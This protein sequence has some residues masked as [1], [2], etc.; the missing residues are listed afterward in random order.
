MNT[1]QSNKTRTTSSDDLQTLIDEAYPTDAWQ[2]TKL[3]SAII[4]Q[5]RFPMRNAACQNLIDDLDLPALYKRYFDKIP[6]M[7]AC[8]KNLVWGTFPP[9]CRPNNKADWMALPL[10][11]MVYNDTFFPFYEDVLHTYVLKLAAKEE[12]LIFHVRESDSWIVLTS[13]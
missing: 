10:E 12:E 8:F 7:L 13:Y 2:R 5:G 11:D 3:E 9:E 6:E 1:Q 4:H